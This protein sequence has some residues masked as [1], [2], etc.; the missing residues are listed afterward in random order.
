MYLELFGGGRRQAVSLAEQVP[1][2]GSHGHCSERQTVT[3]QFDQSYTVV[4]MQC[5]QTFSKHSGIYSLTTSKY[6]QA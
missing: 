2:T 4:I 6:K 5:T 3:A 1:E